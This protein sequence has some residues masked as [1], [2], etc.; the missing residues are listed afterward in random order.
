M[1]TLHYFTP[2]NNAG[3]A[4]K[5][6]CQFLKGCFGQKFLVNWLQ[7]SSL[8]PGTCYLSKGSNIN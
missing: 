4:L 1:T 5:Q 8:S 3:I 6:M 7:T 2:H